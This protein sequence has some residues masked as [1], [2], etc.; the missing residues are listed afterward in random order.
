M[1][2]LARLIIF[3]S[4]FFTILF[5]ISC[6]FRFLSSWIESASIISHN[7]EQG[8]VLVDAA[9]SAL[10]PAVFLAILF[11]LSYSARKEIPAPPSIIIVSILSVVFYMGF[12]LGIERVKAYDP[13][14]YVP[15]S[16]SRRAGFILSQLDT[17]VVFLREETDSAG[18]PGFP[19]VISFPEQPLLY[20]ETSLGPNYSVF[21]LSFGERK[22]W[23]VNSILVDLSICSREFEA[24]FGEDFMSFLIFAS[25]FFFLLS[26]LRFLLDFSS[27]PLANLFL[28]ALI[29]RLILGFNVFLNNR[30]VKTFLDTFVS[31][32]LP[33]YLIIPA[34]FCVLSAVI[35]LYTFLSFLSR[36]SRSKHA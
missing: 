25:A 3:Y 11:S 2:K 10:M 32:R 19:R 9:K 18:N 16:I 8:R 24:R 28:C 33:D 22:S 6:V 12:F 34:V 13:A 20:Q 1:K 5:L 26:S 30:E 17:D 35:I 36:K 7:L 14:M 15:D 31:G 21:S 4:L 27:W 23:L 29:F